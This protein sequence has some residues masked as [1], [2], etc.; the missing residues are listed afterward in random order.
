MSKVGGRRNY[1]YGKTL[2][3]AV[4]SAL[5]ERFG[6]GRYGTQAA[7]RERLGPF[8]EFMR[9]RS[10]RDFRQVT[11]GDVQCYASLLLL[12]R[13]SGE[14]ATATVVNRLSSV[15]VL[16]STLLGDDDVW[17]SP[18]SVFGPRTQ[19]R[20]VP[21][22]GMERAGGRTRQCDRGGWTRATCLPRSPLSTVSGCASGRR[23]C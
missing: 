14:L 5:D 18:R 8:V 17:I 20:L 21:P 13:D 12:A 3:F 22:L 4:R 10:I 9:H 6:P 16:M 23:A 7:H 2:H 19:V 15:N 1:G 11:L